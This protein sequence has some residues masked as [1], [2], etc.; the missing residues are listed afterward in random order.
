M[1]E[2]QRI[3][4]LRQLSW[5]Y[6]LLSHIVDIPMNPQEIYSLVCS[7]VGLIVLPTFLYFQEG[8][9]FIFAALDRPV[10]YLVV[11]TLCLSTPYEQLLIGFHFSVVIIRFRDLYHQTSYNDGQNENKRQ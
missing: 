2:V 1:T 8:Y 5:H 3:F 6:P 7:S 10:N 4:W 11:L 9:F